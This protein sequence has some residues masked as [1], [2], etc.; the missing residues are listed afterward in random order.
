MEQK[1]EEIL[2]SVVEYKN[3]GRIA[4]II[5]NRPEAMN[6]L[7]SEV[8]RGLWHA[9]ENFRD[10]DELWVAILTGAGER[11]FC[12]GADIKG[13]VSGFSRKGMMYRCGPIIYGNRL[14]PPSTV[15]AWAEV[16]NW[17]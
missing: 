2:M 17:R 11:A 5:I 12:A 8:F 4:H 7:N 15:I 6:A 14:S 3:E 13:L 9:F 16:V 10:D 1:Q